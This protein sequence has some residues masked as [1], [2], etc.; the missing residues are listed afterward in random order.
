MN[1]VGAS[2]FEKASNK[3]KWNVGSNHKTYE[4]YFATTQKTS[5]RKTLLSP[6]LELRL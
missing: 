1:A 6:H 4:V 3:Y 5:T 2:K